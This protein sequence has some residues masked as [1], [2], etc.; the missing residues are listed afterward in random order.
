METCKTSPPP[1][2]PRPHAA[3]LK[4][5]GSNDPGGYAPI[6]A[7]VRHGAESPARWRRDGDEAIKS[8]VQSRIQT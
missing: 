4:M 8:F 3:S 2:A 1:R 5:R 6:V 7:A